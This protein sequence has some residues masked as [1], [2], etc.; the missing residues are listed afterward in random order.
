MVFV[1]YANYMSLQTSIINIEN[2]LKFQFGD[3]WI[4]VLRTLYETVACLKLKKRTVWFHGD[5]DSGKTFVLRSLANLFLLVGYI[6][7]LQGKGQFPFQ[8]LYGNRILFLDEIV[9]LPCY[10]DDFKEI[11]AGQSFMINIKFKAPDVTYPC[12]CI[13][14][15][16]G[17]N[18]ID[19]TDTIWSS[20][21]NE[22]TTRSYKEQLDPDCDRSL[23]INPIAWIHLFNKYLKTNFA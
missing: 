16:N 23:Q 20:R 18:V 15:S 11:F 4:N 22:F 1:M 21:V 17:P 14:L 3:N 6:K 5:A 8:D 12:P 19:M 13:V 2:W 10:L 9:L 7:N